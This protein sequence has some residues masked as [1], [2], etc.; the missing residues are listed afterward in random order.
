MKKLTTEFVRNSIEEKEGQII[1][2]NWNYIG[3]FFE[4]YIKC[5]RGHK[6]KTFWN[7]I[8]RNLWCPYCAR[9]LFKKNKQEILDFIKNKDGKILNAEWEY[10][11]HKSKF[12]VECEYGHK[13]KT[14]W[15]NIHSGKHWCPICRSQKLGLKFRKNENQVRKFIENKGGI[16][17][18]DWVYKNARTKI[19]IECSKC[20]G[21]WKT[22]WRNLCH[23]EWCPV[24]ALKSRT[25]D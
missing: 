15:L 19:E 5:E 18:H 21:H 11:N 12:W 6:F 14:S 20:H 7:K 22:T 17:A 10:K 9:D 4:F 8:Q 23:D 2:E 24:C 13:W 1:D 16:L 3:S 25:R